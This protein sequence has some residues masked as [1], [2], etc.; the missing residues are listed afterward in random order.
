LSPFFIR[1]LCKTSPFAQIAL[2]L[3][4][5]PASESNFMRRNAQC[6]QALKMFALAQDIH[7]PYPAGNLTVVQFSYPAEL[8]LNLNKIERRFTQFI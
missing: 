8:P 3:H 7:A 4:F 5:V 6:I 2:K 1:D